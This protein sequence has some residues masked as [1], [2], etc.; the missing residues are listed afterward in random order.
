MSAESTIILALAAGFIGG[1]AARFIEPALT[2]AQ[3]PASPQEIRAQKFVLID[4]TG[5]ARGVFGIETNGA[6]EIEVSD[7][8]GHVFAC[9]FK[10]WSVTHGFFAENRSGGPKR[11]TL[12]PYQTVSQPLLMRTK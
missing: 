5:A 3:A 8:K 10:S 12:L 4:E 11:P 1:L 9:S 2:Y 7:S 6:P